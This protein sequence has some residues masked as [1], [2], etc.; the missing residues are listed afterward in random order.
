VTRIPLLADSRIVV[1]EPSDENAVL[2]P[3]APAEPL[4][5]VV[6]AVRESLSFP[7]EG[8]PLSTLVTRGGS[9]TIVIEQPSLPIP[10]VPFGP[11]HEA[12]AAVADELDELGVAQLTILVACGLLRRTAPRDIGLLVPPEFRR[13]FRGRV[14]VHDAE[15]D[16]LVDVGHLGTVPLRVNPALTE[17]DLVVTVTAAETVLHGGPAALLA[18]TSSE[19]LRVAGALS[20]LEP[21]TS[22]GWRLSVELE[23]RLAERVG[24]FGVSLALNAPRVTGPFAGYPH[25]QAAVDRVLKTRLRRVLQLAPTAVRQRVIERL[26]REQTATVVYSG[27]PSVAH[28]EA[29]LR[30]TMHKGIEVKEP[31]DALVLG[32]PP[33]TPFIPRERPNPVSA[34]YLGL[35]LALRLWRNTPPI[36]P[37]GTAII[38]HPLPRR[39]P[40]PTQTPYRALYGDP[41]T[42]GDSAA[43][44]DAEETAGRDRR[45]LE[46]YRSGRACHPLQPFV[47]WS[48][49][50]ASAHRLGAV[51]VAGCRDAQSARQLGFVPVH[52]L[53]AALE[54]ARGR[55]AR[56]IGYLLAPPY[57]PL[58]VG[59]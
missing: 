38:L 57:A 21:S 58:V 24:L 49:C 39:F 20:L 48:A 18:A 32:I 10:G 1:A 37:G 35:G 33:T 36:V 34:A 54:M 5:D 6:A 28:A 52:A 2:R 47:E 11:R 46:A 59:A 7:L 42:A 30:G 23:R 51:L 55:G 43:M 19:S 4:Q 15:A 27:L 26:P 14:I 45:S 13:R 25:D 9:A 40:H 31:F 3:P 12:I 22:Q 41:R 17:T 53:G 56:R 8:P 16:D 44:R 50:D 29:L